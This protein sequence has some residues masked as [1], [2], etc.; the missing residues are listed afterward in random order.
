MKFSRKGKKRKT[1]DQ[2]MKP[3][4]PRFTLSEIE[5]INAER[6]CVMGSKG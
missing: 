1:G 6:A 2:V 3:F 5:A 4:P